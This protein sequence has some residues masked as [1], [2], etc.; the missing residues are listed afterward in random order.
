MADLQ[1]IAIDHPIAESIKAG[2]WTEK[3][4]GI[5]S[6]ADNT[7]QFL[8]LIL[9]VAISSP[10][11]YVYIERIT[12][13]STS[14]Q[15]VLKELIEEVHAKVKSRHELAANVPQMEVSGRP[16]SDDDEPV[17]SSTPLRDTELLL[18]ERFG[19][20][21]AEND[22]HVREKKELQK[23]LRELHERMTRLQDNNV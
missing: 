15:V 21:M 17:L 16:Q 12:K 13:L 5:G 3:K 18:E 7:L 8:K 4:Y 10:R 1:A 9:L 22:E 11:K 14:T 23:D 20:I 6:P 19:K 2:Y